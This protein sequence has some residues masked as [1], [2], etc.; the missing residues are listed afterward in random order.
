MRSLHRSRVCPLWFC[1]MAKTPY[2]GNLLA[3][4][5]PRDLGRLFGH[6][7]RVTKAQIPTHP[8]LGGS[9]GFGF[10]EMADGAEEAIAGLNGT[11]FKGVVLTVN[12]AQGSEFR[13]S[14][15]RSL[16]FLEAVSAYPDT[17]FFRVAEPNPEYP[18]EWD[19][20]PLETDLL[21]D[22]DSDGLHVMKALNLL[23]DES[24]R[25]YY[26]DIN[27]P[28]RISD[29]A[30]VSENGSLRFGYHHEFPGEILPAALHFTGPGFTL[31]DISRSMLPTYH[32]NAVVTVTELA[33]RLRTQRRRPASKQ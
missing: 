16:P 29:Y 15:G 14:A 10:V 5:T 21:S 27:L 23:P 24:I 26:M 8:A 31:A 1:I 7:G 17:K 20:E 32:E 30:F 12:E 11:K 33:V 6:F 28:E 18:A 19:L 22:T 13:P 25:E 9:M 4:V 2:V 3:S